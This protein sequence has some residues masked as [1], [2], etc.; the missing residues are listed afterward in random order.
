MLS[1]EIPN[2]V[3]EAL[4]DPKW[5]QA[6]TEELDAMYKNDTW[7]LVPLPTGKKPARCKWILMDLEG[8]EQAFFEIN[9]TLRPIFSELDCV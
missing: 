1:I 9:R 5:V 6:M 8:G 3:N 2:N 7:T 4:R